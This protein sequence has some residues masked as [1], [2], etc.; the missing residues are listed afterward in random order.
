MHKDLRDLGRSSELLGKEMATA[1]GITIVNGCLDGQEL[2][3]YVHVFSYGCTQ[4]EALSA[5]GLDETEV[6]F[7]LAGPAVANNEG[8]RYMIYGMDFSARLHGNPSIVAEE[9]LPP[10]AWAVGVTAYGTTH[11]ATWARRVAAMAPPVARA[12]LSSCMGFPGSAV[13]GSGSAHGLRVRRGEEHK[14]SHEGVAT[15]P[16]VGDRVKVLSME[17]EW[18]HGIYLVEAGKGARGWVDWDGGKGSLWWSDLEAA[19]LLWGI[20]RQSRQTSVCTRRG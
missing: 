2:V 4:F 19:G 16:E 13:L 10:K 1:A 17:G 11:G 3:Q 6:T 5:V 15:V 20:V 12:F 8:V 7:T 14:Q 9:L 18:M